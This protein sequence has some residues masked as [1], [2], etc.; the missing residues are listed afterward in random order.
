[1]FGDGILGLGGA[2]SYTGGTTVNAGTLLL[3][4]G[5]SLAPTGRL[6]VNGGSSISTA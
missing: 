6:T 5:G 2:S 4:P 3:G 1:M